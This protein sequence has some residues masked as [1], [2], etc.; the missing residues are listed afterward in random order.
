MLRHEPDQRDEAREHDREHDQG[1]RLGQPGVGA[2]R[3]HGRDHGDAGDATGLP[4]H[5]TQPGDRTIAYWDG[6]DTNARQIGTSYV[7]A[8]YTMILAMPYHYVPVY[9]R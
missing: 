6:I 9:Q 4:E 7:T 2:A 5:P 8:V 3:E 1:P